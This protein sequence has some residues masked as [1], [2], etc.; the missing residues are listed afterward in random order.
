MPPQAPPSGTEQT[1]E[2]VYVG[3]DVGKHWLDVAVWSGGAAWT[4]WRS[5]QDAAGIAALVERLDATG[6]T[7][8]PERQQAA[9]VALE[10]T[11]GLEGAVTAALT[12][13]GW[14][15]AVVNPRRVREFAKAEG[16]LAKTDALDARLLARFAERMRP[17]AYPQPDAATQALAALVERRHQL[18]QMLTAEKHRLQPALPVAH[19][20]IQ[21]HIVWLEQ[22]VAQLDEDLDQGLQ[23]DSRWSVPNQLLQSVPGVGPTV[24]RPLLAHLPELGQGGRDAAKQLATVVGVA[25]LNQDS[26]S[27]RGTRAIWGGRARVR[28][29]LYMAALNG[30]QHNPVLRVCYQQLLARGKAKQVALVACMHKLLLILH[31]ILRDQTPWRLAP[32]PTT[33]TS[34][35]AS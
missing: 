14:R 4:C 27:R 8:G 13:A 16:H 12:A 30:V 33:T 26:G 35:A 3:I 19:P 5:A 7:R 9:L 18:V 1:V 25:P 24:A 22:A 32:Q 21:A 23:G 2:C 10:A 6:T 17:V 11:G 29:A 34:P 28:D 20:Q 31:A 15:V